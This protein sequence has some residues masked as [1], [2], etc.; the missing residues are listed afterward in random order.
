MKTRNSDDPFNCDLSTDAPI[1]VFTDAIFERMNRI[2]QLSLNL[3]ATNHNTDL[4]YENYCRKMIRKYMQRPIHL[5]DIPV[6][7]FHPKGF[8]APVSAPLTETKY[9]DFLN[10][11]QQW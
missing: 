1:E 7:R 3:I 8:K 5:Y 2:E 6:F 4:K 9:E 11:L 10:T